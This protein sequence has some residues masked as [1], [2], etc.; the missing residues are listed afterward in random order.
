M[1]KKEQKQEI[2]QDDELYALLEKAVSEERLCVSEELIQKTLKR[3]RDNVP[4]KPCRRNYY[5]MRYACV[6]ALLVIVLGGGALWLRKGGFT[7]KRSMDAEP[8]AAPFALIERNASGE[9]SIK[10]QVPASEK[11]WQDVPDGE[12]TAP[13]FDESD[14]SLKKNE[15]SEE[16][17]WVPETFA[18]SKEFAEALENA[19]Y[20]V[21]AQEA[22][23]WEFVKEDMEDKGEEGG[24]RQKMISALYAPEE[25]GIPHEGGFSGSYRY[26]LFQGETIRTLISDM[27]LYAAAEVRTE[28]GMLWILLGEKLYLLKEE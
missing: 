3:V 26:C 1:D 13:Y 2:K 6:A 25:S 23:Y 22:E 27:P 4:E 14:G 8:E 7:A 17:V 15:R 18:V 28:Q 16:T 9:G 11:T 19:G 12:K 5:A 20:T 21:S 24:W 10:S